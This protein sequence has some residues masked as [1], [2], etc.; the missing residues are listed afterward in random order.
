[1]S[2]DRAKGVRRVVTGTGPLLTAPRSSPFRNDAA[3]RPSS[4]PP[5]L[6]AHA[7]RHRFEGLVVGDQQHLVE[8]S[9]CTPTSEL[10]ARSRSKRL[11]FTRGRFSKV[12]VFIVL[13]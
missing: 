4:P 12:R 5:R 8:G 7:P 11:V 10:G 1:M 2:S 3:R 13:H 6:G 9:A